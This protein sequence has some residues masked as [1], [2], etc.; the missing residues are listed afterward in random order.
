MGLG[1]IA[2]P[3]TL[4]PLRHPRLQIDGRIARHELEGLIP[5]GIGRGDGHQGP[6][7]ANALGVLLSVV[8]RD[9]ELDQR[10]WLAPTRRAHLHA[11]AL[12]PRGGR[13]ADRRPLTI[14]DE[15]DGLARKPV[16]RECLDDALRL[17][18][19]IKET[20]D[21]YGHRDAPIR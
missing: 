2:G 12:H 16:L 4:P 10:G 7:A 20:D 8:L 14:R 21:G 11:H 9:A 15:A 19:L 13:F 3:T 5:L 18:K 6:P 17:G 1:V